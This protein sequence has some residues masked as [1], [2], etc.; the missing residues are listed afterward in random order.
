MKKYKVLI[1]GEIDDTE[2]DSY[3]AAYEYGVYLQGC[4]RTGAETLNM[5]NPGDYP[6][7]EEDFEEPEFEVIEVDV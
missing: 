3:E 2:F 5:S 6:Y 4:A 1:A 7:D